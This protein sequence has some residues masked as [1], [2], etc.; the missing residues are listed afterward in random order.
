MKE[1]L[2]ELSIKFGSLKMENLEEIFIIFKK[3]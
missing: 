2:I 3:V 1:V